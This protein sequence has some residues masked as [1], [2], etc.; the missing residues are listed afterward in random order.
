MYHPEIGH[1]RK[2]D[3]EK[4]ADCCVRVST[5]RCLSRQTVISG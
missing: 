5:A 2:A 1:G 3:G 4:H